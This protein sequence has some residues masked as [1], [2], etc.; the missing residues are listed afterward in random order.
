MGTV[1]FSPSTDLV[2]SVSLYTIRFTY[3]SV[4]AI[5][6]ILFTFPS[7]FN[8][9]SAKFVTETGFPAAS[10]IS[11]SGQTINYSFP[12]A[13]VSST[14]A[15]FIF[16]GIK[17]P[18]SA[19][20]FSTTAIVQVK[21]A[22]AFVASGSSSAFSVRQLTG[23]DI[24]TSSS[25]TIAALSTGTLTVSG[26]ATFK[27]TLTTTGLL[28]ANGGI[29]TTS[30]SATSATIGSL[31][32][33]TSTL[34][35]K[36]TNVNLYLTSSDGTTLIVGLGNSPF[37][38]YDHLGKE[39]LSVDG[40][41]VVY[42]KNIVVTG[43]SNLM[44]DNG[45]VC[46]GDNP[47]G[48]T[49]CGGHVELDSSGFLYAGSGNF[50]VDSFG[51]IFGSGSIHVAGG[52]TIGGSLDVTGGATIGSGGFVVDSVGFLDSTSVYFN[53]FVGGALPTTQSQSFTTKTSTVSTSLSRD[54]TAL[55][56]VTVDV[57]DGTGSA[58][59]ITEQL[60]TTYPGV[61]ILPEPTLSFDLLANGENAQTYVFTVTGIKGGALGSFTSSIFGCSLGVSC[62]ST[63]SALDTVFDNFIYV[64][65]LPE[66]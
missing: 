35:A 56:Y 37:T 31:S 30:L 6:Q 2:N 46:V 49:P 24:S 50:E 14:N 36:G 47:S 55:V 66:R 27:S 28:T 45:T 39:L 7:G 64:V 42:T 22:T 1:Q 11:I 18:S 61:V 60:T 29:A 5:N 54:A 40:L 10:L 57:K 20:T 13:K 25:L 34:S 8:I 9:A 62:T 52:A 32:L 23:A 12:Q 65:W 33:S 21:N 41:G 53:S 17:N 44:L 38:L 26:A 43:P 59:D 16:Q 19:G 48:G 58:S 4:E 63:L 15:F 51:N 3:I